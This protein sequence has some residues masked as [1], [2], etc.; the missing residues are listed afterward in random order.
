MLAAVA[1]V[2]ERDVREIVDRAPARAVLSAHRRDRER[3]AGAGGGDHR[4]GD[5]T[6]SCPTSSCSSVPTRRYPDRR[7]GRAPVRLRRRGHRRAGRRPTRAQERRHRRAGRDREGAQ[8]AA[9]G[10]GRRAH[11]HR[12]QRR[13]RDGRARAGRADRGPPAEADDRLRRPE[14]DRG[15]LQR[16]RVSTARPW[17]STRSTGEVLSASRAV[18]RTTRT[19]LPPASTARRGRALNTDELRPAAEP[20]HPGPLLAGLDLQ[21]GRRAR[22]ARRRASSRRTSRC[23]APAAPISTAATSS[24]GRRAATAPSTCGTPSSS[25]ATC[26]STRVGNMLGVDRIHKWA[27]LLGLGVKSAASTCRTRS[28]ASC[29]PPSGRGS[30]TGEKWYAGETISVSIGQGQVSVTPVS[31]AVYM[32]TL[33]NGGTRVTPHLVKAVRRRARAGDSMPPPAPQSIGSSHRPRE[34]A[35]DPRRP[36]DGRQR[37]RHRRHGAHRRTRTCRARPAPRRSSRT[38]GARRPRA[39]GK[40]LR[41]NGWFVFF[42]P[43]DNPEIAGVVF[44]EHGIHG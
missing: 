5:S 42:A 14:G 32:A 25:R 39:S 20:R 27:T 15:R 38:T 33:A 22:G 24:A 16:A 21:D 6:S 13:P 10:H 8:R 31:M 44:L 9:D 26:T 37:R 30:A 4:P 43:R 41:D 2:D 1:G 18:R 28:T 35:G 11:G 23:T 12:Q 34:A 7:A 40:D 17:C 19:R 36:L 3:D 29:R